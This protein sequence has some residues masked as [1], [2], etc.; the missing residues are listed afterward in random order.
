MLRNAVIDDLYIR[1]SVAHPRLSGGPK[2]EIHL[3]FRFD[4][5]RYNINTPSI[6]GRISAYRQS[7]VGFQRVL[8]ILRKLFVFSANL[9]FYRL[10]RRTR[11]RP[12]END[13]IARRR[14]TPPKSRSASNQ[15][16]YVMR[17]G[18]RL[19]RFGKTIENSIKS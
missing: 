6:T 10:P 12:P 9:G 2:S 15:R 3:Y 17:R 13:A 18:R 8:K 19:W 4:S 5:V 14:P 16:P 11:R 1:C 7:T